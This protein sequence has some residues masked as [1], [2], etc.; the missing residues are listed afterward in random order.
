MLLVDTKDLI[1]G[2]Q[3]IPNHRAITY[4]IQCCGF[5]PIRPTFPNINDVFIYL[6]MNDLQ[7]QPALYAPPPQNVSP[8]QHLCSI[9]KTLLFQ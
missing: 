7:S 1:S 3:Y 9:Q 5:P 2:I 6:G 4:I 8:L